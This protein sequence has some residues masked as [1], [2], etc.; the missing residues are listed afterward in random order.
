MRYP[1]ERA[2]E[3][4]GSTPTLIRESARRLASV[5]P[6]MLCYTLGITEHTCG[7]N[8]VLTVANLQMLLGNMGMADAAASILSA[9]RTTSR[10]PATWVLC[11]ISFRDTRLSSTRTPVRNLKRHG[12]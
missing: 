5:K 11:R 6:A 8:N 10:G 4:A 3:I 7:V 12:V 2:A 9:A 1:P